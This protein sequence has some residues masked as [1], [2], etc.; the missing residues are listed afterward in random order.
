MKGR[1]VE[2][3]FALCEFSDGV[4]TRGPVA[5]GSR[6]SVNVPLRCP[7]GSRARGIWHTHPDDDD[8]RPSQTDLRNAMD[9]GLEFV[10]VEF[11]KK[12]RCYT[13]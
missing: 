3:G 8:P 2:I 13:V 1:D 5:S 12:T 9:A 7:P 11:R 10:C 6:T 4:L